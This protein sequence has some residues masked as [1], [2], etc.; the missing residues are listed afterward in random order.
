[1]KDEFKKK[2]EICEEIKDIVKTERMYNYES[3][4]FSCGHEKRYP[5]SEK[6]VR[7]GTEMDGKINK[8]FPQIYQLIRDE[9]RRVIV[10]INREEEKISLRIEEQNEKGEWGEVEHIQE[11][12]FP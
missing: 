5:I 7:V 11:K 4:I 10:D 6:R 12:H 8:Y 3:R 1:M 9:Q 2:C